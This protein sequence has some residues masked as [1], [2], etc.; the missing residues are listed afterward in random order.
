MRLE[1]AVF[2]LFAVG[3]EDGAACLHRIAE[4]VREV[5]GNVVLV[6]LVLLGIDLIAVLDVAEHFFAR[7]DARIADV[8]HIAD[9]VLGHGEEVDER[10]R[11]LFLRA[12]GHDPAVEPEVGAFV[13][14][15][16]VEQFALRLVAVL[17]LAR[18]GEV[19]RI[20]RVA[21]PGKV[22]PD[23]AAHDVRL[24]RVRLIAVDVFVHLLHDGFH[25]LDGLFV[26][27]VHDLGELG[28]VVGRGRVERLD[29][30][31]VQDREGDEVGIAHIVLGRHLVA[32][33]RRAHDIPAEFF[34]FVVFDVFGVVDKA[35]HAPHIACRVVCPGGIVGR[36]RLV[37]AVAVEDAADE[38][39]DVADI[40]VFLDRGVEETLVIALEP[41]LRR[42][43]HDHVLGG[44]EQVVVA[45]VGEHELVVHIFVGAEGRVFHA[46]GGAV[47][48]L[49]PRF[50]AFRHGGS[51]LVAVV[52]G[53]IGALSALVHVFLPVVYAQDD[54]VVLGAAR[55]GK[56][57]KGER[58]R[59]G[60]RADALCVHR[61][62]SFLRPVRL[63]MSTMS[64]MRTKMM[65]VSAQKEES[66][67]AVC[68]LPRVV[69]L[70]T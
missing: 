2:R 44:T 25:L 21:A 31:A 60:E 54:G 58:R 19:H 67:A 50:E 33:L 49:V 20:D 9:G 47:R 68:A 27:A 46:D 43:L 65:V 30:V 22:E 39:G 7:N 40:V 66:V 45:L 57:G 24:A 70:K 23:L 64:R 17:V 48:L 61:V 62:S 3:I 10:L 69:A 1:L 41:V 55:K 34:E 52:V 13:G 37:D 11:G 14:D 63:E 32:V 59:E 4:E 8:I 35:R 6:A 12:L 16:E 53:V 28:A 51:L 36:V 26:R 56:Y 15:E 29:L 42:E 18:F 38:G 5:V